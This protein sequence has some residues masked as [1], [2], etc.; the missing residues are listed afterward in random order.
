MKLQK[1]HP[2]HSPYAHYQFSISPTIASLLVNYIKKSFLV[3]EWIELAGSRAKNIFLRLYS[4]D[5]TI[6]LWAGHI[7]YYRD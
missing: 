5:P 2:D 1:L 7:M 4:G 6:N 3:R